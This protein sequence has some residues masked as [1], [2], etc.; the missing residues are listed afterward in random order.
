MSKISEEKAKT[1]AWLATLPKDVVGARQ[2]ALEVT[3]LGLDY[4]THSSSNYLKLAYY[5]QL[6]HYSKQRAFLEGLELYCTVPMFNFSSSVFSST[7]AATLPTTSVWG[8]R[9]QI[10]ESNETEVTITTNHYLVQDTGTGNLASLGKDDVVEGVIQPGFSRMDFTL[11]DVSYG[12]GLTLKKITLTGVSVTTRPRLGT[13]CKL[14]LKSDNSLI[15]IL[16]VTAEGLTTTDG[17][18]PLS[19]APTA[20]VPCTDSQFN[21]LL[22][23]TSGGSADD[24]NLSADI[25]KYSS[26]SDVFGKPFFPAGSTGETPYKQF[27]TWSES[28]PASAKFVR[29]DL[30]WTGAA[31]TLYTTGASGSWLSNNSQSPSAVNDWSAGWQPVYLTPQLQAMATVALPNAAAA[32]IPVD[33]ASRKFQ[34]TGNRVQY[35]DWTFFPDDGRGYDYYDWGPWYDYP[36]LYNDVA[37]LMI[38]PVPSM[39]SS[40]FNGN[41]RWAFLSTIADRLY[42]LGQVYFISAEAAQ[43]A[44]DQQF[45]S[46]IVAWY[47]AKVA[48]A[49]AHGAFNPCVMPRP[50]YTAHTAWRSSTNSFYTSCVNRRINLYNTMVSYLN[51]IITSLDSV[52]NKKSGVLTNSNI[53]RLAIQGVYDTITEQQALYWK[54]NGMET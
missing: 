14:R 45:W 38:E 34:F 50:T 22:G 48:F 16:R 42:G 29:A 33:D 1:A 39:T 5:D 7:P 53:S 23:W 6:K 19:G 51:S 30:R 20:C 10:S 24:I 3:E 37:T 26:T 11:T 36:C 21:A 17:W 44:I 4:F 32:I 54:L 47:N 18:D 2:R 52:I 8:A 46:D 9:A 28:Y 31:T 43:L 27:T 49:S 25:R 12:S 41:S 40:P 13:L 15:G 35:S